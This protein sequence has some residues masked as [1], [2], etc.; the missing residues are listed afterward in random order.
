MRAQVHQRGV[1]LNDL[2]PDNVVSFQAGALKLIDLDAAVRAR[3]AAGERRVYV[4]VRVYAHM[5]GCEGGV[6]RCNQ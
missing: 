3:T 2:K 5:C 1:V 6:L 4:C